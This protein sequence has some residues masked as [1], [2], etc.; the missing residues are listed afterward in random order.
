MVALASLAGRGHRLLVRFS[1]L[2][3]VDGLLDGLL[4]SHRVVCIRQN[5]FYRKLEY[6]HA[7][8]SGRSLRIDLVGR[9]ENNVA[10]VLSL[11]CLIAHFGQVSHGKH[12]GCGW[13]VL[14]DGRHWWSLGHLSETHGHRRHLRRGSWRHLGLR[15]DCRW[16]LGSFKRRE[17]GCASHDLLWCLLLISAI[18]TL[19]VLV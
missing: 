19:P 15:D 11:R 7:D 4:P 14:R 2:H 9:L 5:L 17:V 10:Q 3:S 8:H 12:L 1:L 18:L 6:N 13:L 16:C